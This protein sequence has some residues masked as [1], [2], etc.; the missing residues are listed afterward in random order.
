MFSDDLVADADS[1]LR[2]D[3]GDCTQLKPGVTDKVDVAANATKLIAA[4]R[5]IGLELLPEPSDFV[6]INMR[7]TSFVLPL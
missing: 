5:E 4:M 7:G 2:M 3:G 6:N 1:R